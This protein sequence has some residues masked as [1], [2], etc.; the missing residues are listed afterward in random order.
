MQI[1][2]S[3]FSRIT[4]ESIHHWIVLIH[5][6]NV[7]MVVVSDVVWL[8]WSHRLRDYA[9]SV[10]LVWNESLIVEVPPH[11]VVVIQVTSPELSHIDQW[12]LIGDEVFIVVVSIPEESTVV[13]HLLLLLKP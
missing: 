8:E 7:V 10:L 1:S 13:H 2:W 4:I 5:V 3:S 11:P 6:M 12:F 9:H